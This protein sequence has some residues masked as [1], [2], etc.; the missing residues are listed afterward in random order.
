MD[1]VDVLN[2]IQPEDQVV[3]VKV[4][5]GLQWLKNSRYGK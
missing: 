1:D 5:D 3:S 4:T 2:L